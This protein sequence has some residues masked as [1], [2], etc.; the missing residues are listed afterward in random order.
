MTITE[1]EDINTHTHT[2]QLRYD[3]LKGTEYFVSL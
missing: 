2:F 3:A 1:T